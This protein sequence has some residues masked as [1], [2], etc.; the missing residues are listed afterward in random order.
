VEGSGEPKKEY[1]DWGSNEEKRA[2]LKSVPSRLAGKKE[3][4]LEIFLEGSPGETKG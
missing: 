4:A 1:S 2:L 3:G